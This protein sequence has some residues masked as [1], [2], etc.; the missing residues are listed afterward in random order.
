MCDLDKEFKLC[1]CNALQLLFHQ[2]GWVL[3]RKTIEGP[4][5]V[6]K[7][8]APAK[9]ILTGTETY[10]KKVIV[11]QLNSRNC[12]DFD[13]EPIDGDFLEVKVGDKWHGFS[14]SKGN[15]TEITNHPYNTW[16]EH[17]KKL[18][19]GI[20]DKNLMNLYKEDATNLYLQDHPNGLKYIDSPLFRLELMKDEIDRKEGGS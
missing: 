11:E 15:W 17:L 14:C 5:K 12:F 2:V 1:T 7:G 8:M 10:I 3:H 18:K 6:I 19:R 13:Y 4:S 9:E 20:I 16:R